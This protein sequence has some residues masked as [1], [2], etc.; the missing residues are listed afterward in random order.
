[1]WA[2]NDAT[3][4]IGTKRIRAILAP[5]SARSSGEARA[6]REP[7]C[8]SPSSGARDFFE[9][10]RP[11]SRCWVRTTPTTSG[12]S[13]VGITVARWECR[14]SRSPTNR[15]RW[16]RRP[17]CSD[18]GPGHPPW[19]GD[20]RTA[21]WRSSLTCPSSGPEHANRTL[22]GP[23]PKDDGN[24]GLVHAPCLENFVRPVGVSPTSENCYDPVGWDKDPEGAGYGPLTPA[25]STLAP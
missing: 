3:I 12:T 24:P 21:R 14:R 6:A 22:I 15:S 1:M 23:S 10:S 25:F 19:H 13:D 7:D 5:C 18:L 8:G 17:G 2:V 9:P 16:A 4:N 20:A 11:S